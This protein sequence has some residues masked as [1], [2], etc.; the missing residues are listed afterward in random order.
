[1]QRRATGGVVD[2]P[3]PRDVRLFTFR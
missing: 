2:A 3:L 1:V